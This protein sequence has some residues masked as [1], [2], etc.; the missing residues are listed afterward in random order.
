MEKDTT[1]CDGLEFLRF[2]SEYWPKQSARQD[3]VL[4]RDR[5]NRIQK[6]FIAAVTRA[7]VKKELGASQHKLPK[8]RDSQ[9][10]TYC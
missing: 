6:A 4:A 1:W 7:K 10:K 5:I 3:I 9:G 2:P 8:M